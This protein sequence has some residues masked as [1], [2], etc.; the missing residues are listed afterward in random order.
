MSSVGTVYNNMQKIR[1]T[2]E[3]LAVHQNV[4]RNLQNNFMG[5]LVKE[6]KSK[7][8]RFFIAAIELSTF[9]FKNLRSG[10]I[11]VSESVLTHSPQILRSKSPDFRSSSGK[12]KQELELD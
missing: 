1:N 2:I 10:S 7:F 9:C 5:I 11:T 12:K 8:A 3:M 4:I 6:T